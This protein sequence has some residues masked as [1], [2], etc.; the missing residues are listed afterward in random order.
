M[1]EQGI[2]PYRGVALLATELT[3]KVLLAE[4]RKIMNRRRMVELGRRRDK[5]LNEFK[6]SLVHLHRYT[7]KH[8]LV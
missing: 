5:R 7:Q 3:R 8:E 2:Y 1:F 4:E 6:M